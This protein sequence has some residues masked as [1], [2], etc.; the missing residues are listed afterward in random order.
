[1]KEGVGGGR[2][3][4]GL[5]KKNIVFCSDTGSSVRMCGACVRVC[6]LR[7]LVCGACVCAWSQDQ[8][9]RTKPNRHKGGGHQ[10]NNKEGPSKACLKACRCGSLTMFYA[11]VVKR[12]HVD[13]Q[14]RGKSRCGRLSPCDCRSSPRTAAA[15]LRFV[16]VRRLSWAEVHVTLGQSVA[17]Q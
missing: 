16:V 5:E 10:D 17:T 15:A 4:R 12:A 3:A 11:Q 2:A 1:M 14:I 9:T 8:R 6:L 7:A 13:P